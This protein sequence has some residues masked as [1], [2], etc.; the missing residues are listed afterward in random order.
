MTES[1]CSHRNQTSNDYVHSETAFDSTRRDV[2]SFA[3]DSSTSDGDASSN[4][5]D[6]D[7][8]DEVSDQ[9]RP[10]MEIPAAFLRHDILENKLSAPVAIMDYASTDD[11][12]LDSS[13]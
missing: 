5:N 2:V 13:F 11:S 4:V 6:V 10:T 1:R 7:E 12:L 3:S 9:V 8:P